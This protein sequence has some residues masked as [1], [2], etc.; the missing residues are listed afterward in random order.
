MRLDRPIHGATHRAQPPALR[1]RLVTR[2]VDRDSEQPRTRVLAQLVVAVA[3]A[4]RDEK[5]LSGEVVGCISGAACAEES[6]QPS[7][8]PIEELEEARRLAQRLRDHNRI[9]VRSMVRDFDHHTVLSVSAHSVH[10]SCSGTMW[11]RASV[12]NDPRMVGDCGSLTES[13]SA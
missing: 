7:V 4:E 9:S 2:E 11:A 8:V 1:T 13:F 5:Y 10:G 12:G 3:P 6:V